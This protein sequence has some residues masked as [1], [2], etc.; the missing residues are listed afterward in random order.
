MATSITA[1]DLTVTISE[2]INFN[3]QQQGGTNIVKL[4]NIAE[5]SRR[6]VTIP[7][8]EVAIISLGD[9]IGSGT[10]HDTDVQ[11]IRI[12]N[13]DDTNY[14]SL[15]FE[16]D[17]S[18]DFTIRLDKKRASFVAMLTHAS[19]GMDDYGDISGVSLEALNTI[20]AIANTGSCD[21]EIVVASK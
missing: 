3:G 6:I 18:T 14:V 13:L 10:F 2:K 12:T 5:Y 16:G 1:A 8:S 20:K 9:A 19:L 4:A 17:S 11:Y 7:T 15:N 21:L